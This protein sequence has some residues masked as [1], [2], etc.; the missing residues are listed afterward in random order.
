LAICKRRM[1]Q[2]SRGIQKEDVYLL[3]SACIFSV[4]FWAFLTLF[5][6]IPSYILE[7]SV[8]EIISLASYSFAFALFESL[9]Y[10]LVIFP[11]LYLI[12]L[13]L[14][15]KLLGEHMGP[16]GS[17][18]AIIIAAIVMFIQANYETVIRLSTRRTLFYLGVIGLG[19]L[20]YYI[21]ILLFP[22]FKSTL[23]NILKRLSVLSTIYTVFGVLGIII[24]IIRNIF[25]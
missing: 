17:V 23:Q 6:S 11:V 1:G 14:P 10:F 16:I 9:L 4:F 20:I 22:K 19:F 25:H 2:M 8:S 12:A 13:I 5:N 18:L 15:K 21:L 24:V 7:F 3:L